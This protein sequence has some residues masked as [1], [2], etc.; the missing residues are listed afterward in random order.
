MKYF[1]TDGIRGVYKEKLN[2]ELIKKIGRALSSITSKPIV[3][4][5]DTRISRDNIFSNLSD[6]INEMGLDVHYAG[7]MP[8]PALIYYLKIKKQLGVMITASHNPYFY[9]GLKIIKNGDKLTTIEEEMLEKRID[10]ANNA[11]CGKSLGKIISI[12]AL[13][14]YFNFLNNY[15]PRTNYNITIDCANGATYMIAPKIFKRACKELFVI[16][17]NPDGYNIN[18]GCGSTNVDALKK[19][20]KNNKSDF[21]FAFDG[22]GDR[23]ICVDKDGNIY[24]GDLI[25]YIIAMYLKR[26]E[27]L[28]KNT[29]CMSIMCNLG[30]VKALNEEGIKVIEKNV[31]DKNILNEIITS[32]LSLG[33]ESSGHIIYNDRLN[34]GDGILIGLTLI[35]ILENENKSLTELT[36][37]VLLYQ[38]AYKNI[39]FDE[40]KKMVNETELKRLIEKI[41]NECKND[42]K[43]IVRKSGTEEVLRITVM[44]KSYDLSLR[45]LLQIEDFINKY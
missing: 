28:K 36:K 34:T 16:G 39:L 7:I 25:I 21:G 8:T 4:A 11:H 23:V 5:T 41:K 13:D 35:Q 42:C 17:D 12:N 40:K 37:N 22:D 32:D 29:V 14:D 2:D 19:N 1:G 30:I 10:D 31:G 45:Y 26:R 43:I 38:S 9:N 44:T 27:M 24:D 3:V 18:D 33:G 20:V 15:I 6:G